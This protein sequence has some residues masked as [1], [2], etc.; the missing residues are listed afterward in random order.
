MGAR[1]G[2]VKLTLREDDADILLRKGR[3]SSQLFNGLFES[4]QLIER[5]GRAGSSQYS[6]LLPTHHGLLAPCLEPQPLRQVA[7]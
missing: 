5:S 4:Y 2:I 7:V 1:A 3:K 6:F